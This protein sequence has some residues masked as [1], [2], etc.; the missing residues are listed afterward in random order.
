MRLFRINESI[1]AVSV[2]F[3]RQNIVERIADTFDVTI[4]CIIISMDKA[5]VFNKISISS[6]LIYFMLINFCFFMLKMNLGAYTIARLAKTLSELVMLVN[7]VKMH[8]P[9]HAWMRISMW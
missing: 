4:R 3:V 6:V 8:Y 1:I 2:T 5:H 7:V 9:D